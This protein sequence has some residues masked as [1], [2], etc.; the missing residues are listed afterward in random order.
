MPDA[1][2]IAPSLVGQDLGPTALDELT[3][4]VG[5]DALEPALTWIS[6]W[7][8]VH[9]LV[10]EIGE[11][12]TRVSEIVGALKGYTHL[13]QSPLQSVDLH[14]GIDNT[15]VMLRNTL[16]EGITIR[17]EFGADV[18]SLQAYGNELNQVWTN[19]L[20]NAVEAIGRDG[21]IVIRTLRQG[22]WVAVEIEDNGPGIPD[23]IRPRIFDP[24]FTTKP[25]G[26]G[27]GLGLSISHSIVTKK[28]RGEL[29]VDSRPGRTRFIVRLPI[30]QRD[31]TPAAAS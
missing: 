8:R 10:R 7:Y 14:D 29:R 28:H 5:R 27:T 21:E 31:T 20:G 24:F 23:E 2:D 1:W 26:K 15:L 22:D 25:P 19:L 13:G 30:A 12:S 4:T 18:P 16:T 11:S 3:A 9:V 6:W 17:R